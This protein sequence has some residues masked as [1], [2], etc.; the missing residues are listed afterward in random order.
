MLTNLMLLIINLQKAVS[1]SCVI[2]YYV[3]L[4]ITQSPLSG[5]TLTF[6]ILPEAQNLAPILLRKQNEI[7]ENVH[8]LPTISSLSYIY[9]PRFSFSLLLGMNSSIFSLYT[10]LFLNILNIKCAV[11]SPI[12]KTPNDKTLFFHY[13]LFQRPHHLSG[14]VRKSP[15]SQLQ[16]FSSCLLL[17]PFLSGFNSIIPLRLSSQVP[18]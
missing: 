3:G 12:L 14:L 5:P 11:V 6:S 4:Q 9:V 2:L 13:T 10:G 17:T 7:E 15:K 1:G 18:C 8:K 16:F